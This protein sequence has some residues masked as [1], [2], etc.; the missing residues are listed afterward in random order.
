[1]FKALSILDPFNRTSGH[2]P[3]N[4]DTSCAPWVVEERDSLA[5]RQFSY[6]VSFASPYMVWLRANTEVSHLVSLYVG[7]VRSVSFPFCGSALAHHVFHVLIIRAL[8]K[9]RRIATRRVVAMVA[10]KVLKKINARV[11]EIRHAAGYNRD[12]LNLK[13]AIAFLGGRQLP[14]PAF[15][16]TAD[17]NERP[18]SL[19]VLRRQG[20]EL[21]MVFG[22]DLTSFVGQI[23]SR[24]SSLLTQL[25]GPYILTRGIRYA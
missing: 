18:K 19:N 1:M 14:R 23:V 20:R 21:T 13:L 12:A 11:Q 16:G 8:K 25:R 17:V 5:V 9:M 6:A 15:I 3:L 7:V 24:A 10:R 22:H 4:G 2:P